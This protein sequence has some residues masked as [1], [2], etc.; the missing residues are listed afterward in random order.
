MRKPGK[1]RVEKFER[2]CLH[3]STYSAVM[4]FLSQVLNHDKFHDLKN[5]DNRGDLTIKR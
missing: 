1:L 5:M 4:S 3:L 2:F